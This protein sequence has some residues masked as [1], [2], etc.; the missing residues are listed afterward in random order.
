MHV[1]ENRTA[2][3]LKQVHN[4]HTKWCGIIIS[5][6]IFFLELKQYVL[7]SRL[8]WSIDSGTGNCVARRVFV[9]KTEPIFLYL[10]ICIS[11]VFHINERT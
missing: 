3:N 6:L 5:L 11:L 10:C 1:F 4:K 2:V 8:V 9:C 7:L